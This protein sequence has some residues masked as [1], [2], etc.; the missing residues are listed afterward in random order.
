MQVHWFPP[1]QEE[2]VASLPRFLGVFVLC[3]IRLEEAVSP[4]QIDARP[5][6]CLEGGFSALACPS[7]PSELYRIAQFI[8]QMWEGEWV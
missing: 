1:L 4:E 2:D 3:Q 8:Y 7:R 6:I 5:G